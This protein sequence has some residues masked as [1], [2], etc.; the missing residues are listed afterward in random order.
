[1][2]RTRALFPRKEPGSRTHVSWLMRGEPCPRREWAPMATD[3]QWPAR[4]DSAPVGISCRMKTETAVSS[5]ASSWVV[6]HW[7][8]PRVKDGDPS[9]RHPRQGSYKKEWSKGDN[10]KAFLFLALS[11][12]FSF[13]SMSQYPFWKLCSVLPPQ[14]AQDLRYIRNWANKCTPN[15]L[16][17]GQ[18]L[19]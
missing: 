6:T 11:I 15:V 8:S 18:M 1:M 14:R 5:G 9:G 4:P 16:T 12:P 3:A 19:T 2:V 13:P 17:N 10:F 7:A